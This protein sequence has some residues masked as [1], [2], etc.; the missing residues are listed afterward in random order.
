MKVHCPK[1]DLK[2][3]DKDCSKCE[4]YTLTDQLQSNITGYECFYEKNK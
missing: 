2:I 1:W 3:D 4:C